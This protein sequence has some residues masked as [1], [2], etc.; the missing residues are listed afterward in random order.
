MAQKNTLFNYFT[1]SPAQSKVQ[2]G[3]GVSPSEANN[4]ILQKSNAG[5]PTSASKKVS[6]K[7]TPK[8]DSKKST[9][10]ATP[11]TEGN[12]LKEGEG[13]WAISTF[14]DVVVVESI[15]IFIHIKY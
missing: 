15:G 9:E 1:K 2:S 13:N 3:C 14:S 5:T 10:T 4:K 7:L 11:A 6:K 12:K 8:T